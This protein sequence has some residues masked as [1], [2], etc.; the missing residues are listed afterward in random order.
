MAN[1]IFS[2]FLYDD[3]G[4]AVPS[5]T[6]NLYDRNTTTPSRADTTTNSAGYWTISHSTEG[7]FDV[8]ITSGSSKR[9]IKY[10]EERQFTTLEVAN[11][12][13][14][15][16]A[17][18]FDYSI[19]PA[20]IVADR[21]LT[22][23][24]ITATDTLP[25]IGLAQTWSA[26]QTHSANISLSANAD[27]AF[28][29]TT[30]TNDIVLTNGLADALS[31]TDGSADI[32]VVNT[33]TSG[34]VTTFTSALSVVSTYDA[35][36]TIYLREN[37]GTSGTIK[38]HAD[39]GTSV[40]EAAE[41]INILSDAGGVGIR[42]T[43]NLAKAINLTSDGGTTGS[44]A[45]F[46]D[47][48]T[49]VA[50]GTE[51]ISILSDDGGVGIR[52]TA[53]LA[54]AINLTS[55]GGATGSIAIFNDQG[56]SVT[57]GAESISLL[58]D[59]GGVGI[60]STANLANAVNITVDGGTTSTM[61]LFNDQGTAA[62]EGAASIQLLSDAGGVNI[63]SG[64]NGANAILLTA[65]GGTS[66]TI[67]IHA[68]QGSGT[69]SIE[70]LS[71]AGGIEIDAGTDI[72]LDAGGADIFLKDDGTLFGTLNNNSGELLIKSSSSGTTAAT[73]SGANVTFAGTVDATTDFT[74]GSTVITDDVITF[75]PSSSDTVT[76][77]SSTNGAFSLVTVDDAAAAANIQ[78]TADGTVD[79][80]SAGVLTLDSGAAINI[81]P[82]GGSAILLD[83]TI[84][85]DA[86]VVTGV[87]SI[88]QTDVKIGEDDET[89]ID[90]ET[91]NTINFYANN[92]KDL[93]LSENA[94][95]PGTSDGTALGTASLMW[96]DLF[97]AS[98]SVVNFNN[99]DVTLTHSANTLTFDGGGIVFNEA[100]TLDGDLDFTGP[101]AITT[102]SGEITLNAAGFGVII[103]DADG[104]VIG[105]TAKVGGNEFQVLGTGGDDSRM[106]L[107]RWSADAA[108][109]LL[110]FVKSRDPAIADGSFAAVEDNDTVGYLRWK[111]DDGVDFDTAVAQIYVE[112]DDAAIAQSQI[113]GAM[114][115]LTASGTVSD[116][117]TERMRIDAAGVVTIPGNL[118]LD[119]TG[120][121]LNVGAAAS[122]WTANR[123]N[124]EGS[125]AGGT[126]E[127]RVYNTDNSDVGSKARSTIVSGG[128]NAG[129]PY[130]LMAVAG[131]VSNFTIGI[132]NSN[133]DM[134]VI[135]RGG[136][137][138][139]NDALRITDATPPVITYNTTH[140]TG[141]FDYVCESC[142]RHEGAR[143]TCCGKVEWHDDVA[144]AVRVLTGDATAIDQMSLMGVMEQT[145][146]ND[147]VPE[148]FT[149][150][151]AD[152]AFA[153]SMSAQNRRLIDG[154]YAQLDRRIRNLE[155]A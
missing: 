30:G 112:V 89:K 125:N 149:V 56:T 83:G 93:V 105:H 34:N 16:P 129:D 132:D 65:D 106:S 11:L 48:G 114:V 42:S 119:S 53:N 117:M 86:G 55:D 46:N 131:G 24:L 21:V 58:S 44:I 25:A 124:L 107:G 19:L 40:T 87:A 17:D 74:I 127:L 136:S 78:I 7:R 121:I 43:A 122:E 145:R 71:D 154:Q 4:D 8:E 101:Q 67:V 52:S 133:S 153:W 108:S 120:T 103:P 60:R 73:F 152:V 66:E 62:T 109:P 97:L 100:L 9:R 139:T 13:I 141:T 69:G 118:D 81:E 31:I 123:V 3:G 39:Q 72:I 144:L 70:L 32:I 33:S 68:D 37:A 20:A 143:F 99:G 96:S 29:G 22:L 95:T 115:F 77:T 134:A 88:F 151:G 41:S 36:A 94:L 98:G 111:V 138:G 82:A 76:L 137:L 10:D 84:S 130:V 57:E 128:A 116:N 150:L 90:F 45:I 113:G 126:S 135:S 75:T 63:K 14:R 92:A 23:P 142:G 6:V 148:I 79:I 54:K 140:P 61:T 27:I 102:T 35:A 146:D 59:V 104:L 47:Q 50:E 1:Q 80:D 155:A 91:A 26:V 64:L 49:S 85:I 18:T 28:T 2:G 51:S 147:G 12:N 15:N 38:I 5:A 110:D